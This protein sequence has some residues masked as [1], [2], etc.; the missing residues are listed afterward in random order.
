MKLFLNDAESPFARRF[1]E[2]AREREHSIIAARQQVPDENKHFV[3]V[4]GQS[5]S[6]QILTWNLASIFSV[7][8]VLRQC[9]FIWDDDGPSTYLFFLQSSMVST[10]LFRDKL[11]EVHRK[12]EEQ[13]YGQLVLLREL[14]SRRAKFSGNTQDNDR[15]V[16]VVLEDNNPVELLGGSIYSALRYSFH[17]VLSNSSDPNI[18]GFYTKSYKYESFS[19]FILDNLDKRPEKHIGKWM[20]FRESLLPATMGNSFINRWK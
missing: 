17:H 8:L 4:E 15:I 11:H 19:K 13:L 9:N 7:R 12:I 16:F 10:S 18:F 2:V 1:I 5:D 20:N 14:E 6:P 3:P